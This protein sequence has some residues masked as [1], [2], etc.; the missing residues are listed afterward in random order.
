MFTC[1]QMETNSVSQIHF[2]IK[3][4]PFESDQNP[5]FIL[6]V[7]LDIIN[8]FQN[9]L[10]LL[11]SISLHWKTYHNLITSLGDSIKS[12]NLESFSTNLKLD[13]VT[14]TFYFDWFQSL[15]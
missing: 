12:E 3:V 5:Y 10:S 9:S 6:E 13:A 2:F 11:L 4:F 8:S 14:R 15:R 7:D 1:K